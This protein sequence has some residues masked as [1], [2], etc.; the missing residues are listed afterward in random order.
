MAFDT[1]M[2]GHIQSVVTPPSAST[3]ARHTF[4]ALPT[5]FL[6]WL[7]PAPLGLFIFFSFSVHEV[8]RTKKKLPLKKE[9]KSSKHLDSFILYRLGCS[10]PN[11]Y[12]EFGLGW[13][14]TGC[15]LT[16]LL[17]VQNS[18]LQRLLQTLVY[19]HFQ[20]LS[21]KNPPW[22]W[23]SILSPVVDTHRWTKSEMHSLGLNGWTDAV[24]PIIHF[25]KIA[26][27]WPLFKPK[28]DLMITLK[29]HFD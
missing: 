23:S 29:G 15:R 2:L 1:Q 6:R 3:E 25:L 18:G 4:P 13:A 7:L 20:A 27:C 19:N 10:I 14:P 22:R 26:K 9:K 12:M 28:E 21:V 17:S 11:T 8:L 16:P 5:V 24:C